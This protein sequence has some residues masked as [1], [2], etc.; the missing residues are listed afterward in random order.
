MLMGAAPKRARRKGWNDIQAMQPESLA[1]S[2]RG[3]NHAAPHSEV[4]FQRA[5]ECVNRYDLTV[6]QE[7]CRSNPPR[8]SVLLVENRKIARFDFPLAQPGIPANSAL[9]ATI[10]YEI[11]AIRREVHIIIEVLI[12]GAAG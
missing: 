9:V 7:T 5:F 10:E 2:I 6:I 12:Q 3:D 8:L 4:I 1:R 11:P